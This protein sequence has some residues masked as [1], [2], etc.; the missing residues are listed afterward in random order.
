MA[1]VGFGQLTRLQGQTQIGQTRLHGL[2]ERRHAIV[3]EAGGHGAK[4]GHLARLLA[5]SFLVAL[6][7]L[8]HIAQRVQ[9]ALAVK[10]V[11]G[12]ELGKVKHVDFFE[13]AGRAK[14]R[15]HHIQRHIHMRHD[16]GIALA[17]A[18]RFHDD[19]IKAC[20]LACSEHVRQSLRDFAAEISRGE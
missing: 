17:N 6:H 12:H 20:S 16:G 11:D 15:R 5:P 4:H 13:L 19:E 18:A 10:F 14:L 2:V 1:G 7:L 9:R 8:G 3:V